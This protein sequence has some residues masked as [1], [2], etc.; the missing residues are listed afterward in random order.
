MSI[1]EKGMF[2]AAKALAASAIDCF[3][4]PDLVKAAKA[5][6]DARRAKRT[7]HTLLPEGQKPPT[8]IR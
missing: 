1:G 6:F 8:S 7:F 5:D 3:E 4:K 2:L